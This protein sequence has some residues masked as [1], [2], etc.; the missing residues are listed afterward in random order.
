MTNT[1]DSV[2]VTTTHRSGSSTPVY[3]T[4]EDCPYLSNNHIQRDPDTLFDDFEECRH[5]AGDTG[6]PQPDRR[7]PLIHRIDPDD[8]P[9]PKN[10]WWK[11]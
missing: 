10:A 5:C 6:G 8:D 9:T 2:W 1:H 4:N 7:T 3:H 11:L